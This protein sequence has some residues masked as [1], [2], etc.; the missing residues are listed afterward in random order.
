ML[1]VIN[2]RSFSDNFSIRST[3][4]QKL[5]KLDESFAFD[6]KPSYDPDWNLADFNRKFKSLQHE[7]D[8][9][10]RN[11]EHG[12][13]ILAE[14]EKVLDGLVELVTKVRNSWDSYLP[15][16]FYIH[17]LSSL[18]DS[19]KADYIDK[20]CKI[21]AVKKDLD[22]SVKRV[23]G[24]NDMEIY[25]YAD[26]KFIIA[27]FKDLKPE[28]IDR[29]IIISKAD[30]DTIFPTVLKFRSEA[31]FF[32]YQYKTAAYFF[33]INPQQTLERLNG[34]IERLQQEYAKLNLE[35]PDYIE[36]L[37]YRFTEFL[38]NELK[39]NETRYYSASEKEMEAQSKIYTL[40]I[41]REEYKDE[42]AEEQSRSEKD[43]K[44]KYEAEKSRIMKTH[45]G[46]YSFVWKRERKSWSETV[47]PVYFDIGKDYLFERTGAG[48]LIKVSIV[49]FLNRHLKST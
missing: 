28:L 24:I 31:D 19:L 27:D 48:S 39:L 41:E 7:R 6:K 14:L 4:T 3:V 32:S 8:I 12:Q 15:N 45:K 10:K 47:C 11:M 1:W 13:R 38:Q 30:K 36:L 5:R 2:A 46:R 20:T 40:E 9:H 35:L 23:K 42:L 25:H 17:G 16:Q 49:E 26:A 21:S 43:D 44:L 33:A 34:D 18:A 37:I 22:E 29:C